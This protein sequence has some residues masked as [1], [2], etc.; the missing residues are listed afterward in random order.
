M[1]YIVNVSTGIKLKEFEPA[2][3]CG[4]S[5]DITSEQASAYPDGWLIPEPVPVADPPKKLARKAAA[6]ETPDPLE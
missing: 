2:V 6:D 3:P 4:H 5:I 1:R